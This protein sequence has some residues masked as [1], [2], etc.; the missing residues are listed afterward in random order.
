MNR[1]KAC[2]KFFSFPTKGRCCDPIC[3]W[4]EQFCAGF[5]CDC[6]LCWIKSNRNGTSSV[7]MRRG[8]EGTDAPESLTRLCL[9]GWSNDWWFLRNPEFISHEGPYIVAS[10]TLFQLF[11]LFFVAEKALFFSS[12]GTTW[13]QGWEKGRITVPKAAKA[14]S[15][16]L[17]T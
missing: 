2:H 3:F 16:H 11:L 7:K 12:G 1:F 8:N 17:W 4:T 6:A 10:S 5:E 14:K 15:D 13:W 9:R